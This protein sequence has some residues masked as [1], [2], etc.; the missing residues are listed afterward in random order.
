MTNNLYVLGHPV[1]HSKSPVM[2]NAL[3]Q[4]LGLDWRYDLKDCQTSAE[5]CAFIQE[6]G[7]L[8]LNITMPYKQEAFELAQ[9][10]FP[11]AILARGAN[12]L[13][14]D[15]QGALTCHNMDGE[16]CVSY[17]EQC[18]VDFLGATVVVC[19][20]GPTSLAIM[21]AA[22]VH[23]ASRITLVGR[24][25]HRTQLV[26]EGYL[27][28]LALSPD[29]DLTSR[30]AFVAESYA[31]ASLAF[32]PD[33]KMAGDA[34]DNDDAPT[35]A[36]AG[37][38]IDATPLGMK[39]GDPAPFD[40]SLLR[41]GQFVFD[42][43]YGHGATALAKGANAAGCRFADGA[44]MLVSQAVLG[45]WEFLAAGGVQ[46]DVSYQEAFNLMAKAA[47]FDVAVV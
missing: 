16:G 42:V 28:R 41:E 10:R 46:Q 11:S 2:H 36:Q 17:L 25:E 33:W 1:A 47:G 44:G 23:G 9:T 38:V 3:Y 6:G 24:D 31:Q 39:E 29:A 8:G 22:A 18:G 35:I 15:A 43:V 19:G 4:S 13:Y 14:R 27:E 40:V 37:I 45:A 20:T 32:D 7:Y 21:H 30:C 34:E 26:T 12:V 5:A